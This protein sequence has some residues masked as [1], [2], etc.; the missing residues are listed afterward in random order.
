[1]RKQF[2]EKKGTLW[3][4]PLV[5]GKE[6]F[7]RILLSATSARDAERRVRESLI[8]DSRAGVLPAK[9]VMYA[10]V[11]PKTRIVQFTFVPKV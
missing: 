10:I 3:L 2:Q 8:D 4:V 1:M 7:Q 5:H 9:P 11:A 6:I